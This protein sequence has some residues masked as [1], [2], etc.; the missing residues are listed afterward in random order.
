MF[1]YSISVAKKR[2]YFMRAI[3]L[4]FLIGSLGVITYGCKSGCSYCDSSTSYCFEC[5]DPNSF[6]MTDGTCAQPA[7]PTPNCL[8]YSPNSDCV[9]C[10][11]TYK[12]EGGS[13]VR[14]ESGCVRYSSNG[15]CV[16]CAFGTIL[17]GSKCN[18]VTHCAMYS[19][20]SNTT[21]AM[22]DATFI[23][24]PKCLPA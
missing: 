23:P 16:E 14:D 12:L 8:I 19:D 2:I 17:R 11:I 10:A 4:A 7:K 3:L 13:C 9:R 21:C 5:T 18:G 24:M 1:I 6:I 15:D 20:S 22:C